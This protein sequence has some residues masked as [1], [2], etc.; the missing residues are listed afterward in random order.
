[1][2]IS[3]RVCDNCG[4]VNTSGRR[5]L[6]D[7]CYKYQRRNKKPRPAFLQQGKVV[8]SEFVAFRAEPEQYDV[9]VRLAG[10]LGAGNNVSSALRWLVNSIPDDE[11]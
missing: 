2:N 11:G 1:M 10:Q 4:K 8:K 6:C 3:T 7:A 9:L 5:F